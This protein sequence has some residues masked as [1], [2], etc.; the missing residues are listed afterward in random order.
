MS[1]FFPPAGGT[2]QSFLDTNTERIQSVNGF[3]NM[4]ESIGERQ[5][6]FDPA[7]TTT[8]NYKNASSFIS[9]LRKRNV[10]QPPPP[11]APGVC[12]IPELILDYAYGQYEASYTLI[13]L[14]F[15]LTAAPLVSVSYV[16]CKWN[17]G[18]GNQLDFKSPYFN[19][20]GSVESEGL[21]GTNLTIKLYASMSLPF[22]SSIPYENCTYVGPFYILVCVKLLKPIMTPLI[23]QPALRQ[24]KKI[25]S[26]LDKLTN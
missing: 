12:P 3:V 23:R 20:S 25:T 14:P 1:N 22:P 11:P 7:Q 2:P 8:I 18:P 10:I 26:L 17:D 21:P 19:T 16:G 13:N 9:V 15:E 5:D 4:L 6:V 24:G